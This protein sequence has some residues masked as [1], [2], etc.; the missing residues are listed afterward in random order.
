M[1]RISRELTL[2]SILKAPTI[3]TSKNKKIGK[4]RRRDLRRLS[5]KPNPK[6][7]KEARRIRLEKY[8]T[9]RTWEGT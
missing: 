9:S 4:R 7:K 2:R 8:P 6:P 1:K 5:K 3:T